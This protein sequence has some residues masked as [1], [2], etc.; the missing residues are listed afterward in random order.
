MTIVMTGVDDLRALE[1][2]V[3]GTTDWHEVTQERINA[4]ADATEDWERLHVDPERAATSPWGV[5]IA[6][7]LYTLSLGP[8]FQYELF[9]MNGHSLALNYGYDKV[10][11]LNPVRVGSRIRMTAELLAVEP[12]EGGS[13]FR[14]K[15]TFEIEGEEKPACVAESLFAYF[16]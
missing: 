15:Q 7:G 9:E 8:K 11:W 1:G 5:T 4:F 3:I 16:D 6:H 12:V 10:R 13:K 14:M 2:T